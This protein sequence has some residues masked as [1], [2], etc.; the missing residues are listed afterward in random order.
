[1]RVGPFGVV[2][3]RCKLLGWR[4]VT[5][6]VGVSVGFRPTDLSPDT[7]DTTIHTTNTDSLGDCGIA[8]NIGY[9]STTLV[10][11]VNR[12]PAWHAAIRTSAAGGLLTDQL[13]QLLKLRFPLVTLAD[14]V[15]ESLK[16]RHCATAGSYSEV[17][18][19]IAAAPETAG[20]CCINSVCVLYGLCVCMVTQ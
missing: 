3:G 2:G 15:A 16:E 12:R 19:A 5:A 20:E 14:G 1:M 11:L 17:L 7:T 13:E 6:A 4:H 9:S 8:V 18:R 10:P